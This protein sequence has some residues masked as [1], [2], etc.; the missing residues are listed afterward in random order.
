[1]A[2]NKNQH[3]VPRC[4]LGKFS[5]CDN[6]KVISLY[7][8][9]KKI[10][11]N[12]APIKNQ[13]SGS[14]FY[15]EDPVHEEMIQSVEQ[16]YS[17]VCRLILS[18]DALT[19]D[20][21]ESLKNFW[22]LQYIRTE[23]AS[24][25]DLE[26]YANLESSAGMDSSEFKMS[27]KDAVNNSLDDYSVMRFSIYDLKV[28]L[29]KNKSAS[30]FVTSD[31][32]AV[33]I[34]R[35]Y[36]STKLFEGIGYGV[37]SAGLICLLPISPD[38]MCVIFDGDVYSIP[39]KN[40]WAEIKAE[41]DVDV[42]NS[43]QVMKCYSNLYFPDSAPLEDVESLVQR[44][45]EL[46]P[47]ATTVTN[48]ARLVKEENGVRKFEAIDPDDAT[49]HAEVLVHYKPVYPKIAKWPKVIKWKRKAVVYSTGTAV[50]CVRKQEAISRPFHNF[51]KV[52]IK[53]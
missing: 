3:F 30:K 43:H 48:Y 29:I 38:V 10:S 11:I 2:T 1:M 42:F 51:R 9:D 40:G 24:K 16:D 8:I 4:H 33:M 23:A 52:T 12:C 35:V 34:N 26:L 49:N 41:N 22:F 37:S 18:G 19:E 53:K 7:N 28:C 50:G 15:G 46:R 20:M 47:E 17:R 13:C 44:Y 39:H 6:P 32:P 21:R 36:Y 25:R 45:T 5:N 27:I 14:Y 31:D